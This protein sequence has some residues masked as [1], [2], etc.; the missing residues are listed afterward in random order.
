M[1]IIDILL[2]YFIKI[3]SNDKKRWVSKNYLFLIK[4]NLF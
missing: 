4:N 2:S 3:I 1:Y